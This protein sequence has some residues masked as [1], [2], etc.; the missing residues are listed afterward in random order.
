M[1]REQQ[2]VAC[3]FKGHLRQTQLTRFDF[4]LGELGER[5]GQRHVIK[6]I[7]LLLLVDLNQHIP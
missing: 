1:G 4:F 5:V 7:G 3:L 6:Q 2:A